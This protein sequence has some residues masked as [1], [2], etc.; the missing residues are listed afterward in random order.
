[1]ATIGAL[2]GGVGALIYA[3]EQSVEASGTEVHPPTM[4]WGHSG[5]IQSLDH[6]RFVLDDKLFTYFK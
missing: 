3:L 5:L 4:P 1:M 2:T 6:S